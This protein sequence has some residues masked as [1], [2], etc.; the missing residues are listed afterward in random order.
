MASEADE[1]ILQYCA[2][3]SRVYTSEYGQQSLDNFRCRQKEGMRM[4]STLYVHYF[5]LK[6]CRVAC[7]FACHTTCRDVLYTLTPVVYYTA[8]SVHKS[9]PLRRAC[10]NSATTATYTPA[11]TVSNTEN[12]GVVIETRGC[13]GSRG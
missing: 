6:S 12:A 7:A 3:P 10:G 5:Q 13:E 9:H 2:R 8:H 1:H 4:I 11:N